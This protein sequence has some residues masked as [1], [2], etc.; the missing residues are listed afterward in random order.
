M[1][2]YLV[3]PKDSFILTCVKLFVLHDC[4]LFPFLSGEM[5]KTTRGK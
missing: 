2:S 3:E 1:A 4:T 5:D